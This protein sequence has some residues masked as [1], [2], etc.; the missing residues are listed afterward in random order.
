[1]FR[2]AFS[3]MIFRVSAE[4]FGRSLIFSTVVFL[5]ASLQLVQ[6]KKGSPPVLRGGCSLVGY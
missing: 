1:M 2:L 6:S 5:A 3:A 4:I